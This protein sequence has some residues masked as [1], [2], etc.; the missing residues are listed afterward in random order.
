MPRT[1]AERRVL[2]ENP[3]LMIAGDQLVQQ[4]IDEYQRHS[5]SDAGSTNSDPRTP[6][7]PTTHTLTLGEESDM[8]G[9]Q[10]ETFV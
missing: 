5:S 4:E 6:L 1:A 7:S 2:M 10:R 3:Q 8:Q 9:H